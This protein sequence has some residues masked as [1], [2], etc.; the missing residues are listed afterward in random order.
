MVFDPLSNP[1]ARVCFQ[2]EVHRDRVFDVPAL[3]RSRWVQPRTR[4]IER[5]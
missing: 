3:Q 2:L 4:R 5:W 1:S